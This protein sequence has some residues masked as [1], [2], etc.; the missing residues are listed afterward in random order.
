MRWI[1][2]VTMVLFTTTMALADTVV[3]QTTTDGADDHRPPDFCRTNPNAYTREACEQV[4][5]SERVRDNRQDP[6]NVTTITQHQTV[7]PSNAM[8]AWQ[9]ALQPP[10][11]TTTVEKNTVTTPGGSTESVSSSQTTTHV[12]S[13][14]P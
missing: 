6:N 11:T 4:R 14:A 3:T 10:V 1:I 5:Q 12:G 13:P 2:T 7:E 9:Q 8:P